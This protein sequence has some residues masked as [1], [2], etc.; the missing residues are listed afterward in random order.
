MLNKIKVNLSSLDATSTA[1]TINIPLNIEYQLVDQAELIQDV[2]VETEVDKS[3]NPILDYEKVRFLP[4]DLSNNHIDKITYDLNFSGNLSYGQ[5]GFTDED[6]KFQK[7]SFLQTYLHLSF[8][9]TDNPLDQRLITFVTLY[10][11]LTPND[12]LPNVETQILNYGSQVGIPSQPKPANDIPLNFVLESPLF[13]PNGVSEGFHIYDFKD[14]LRVGE[15]KYLYMRATFNN[16]K[17][18]KSTNLMVQD[19]AASIDNLVHLLYTRYILTRTTTG[20]YYK[21]DDEYHGLDGVVGP[22]NV[23]YGSN[24]VVIKLFNIKAL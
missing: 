16:A 18:G 15:S 2:F 13:N 14:E 10:P 8:Y 22:N 6:I 20:F 21:I 5:I 12:L 4:L 7:N 17:T 9:D 11:E 23:T 3:I 1:T 24:T 19:A